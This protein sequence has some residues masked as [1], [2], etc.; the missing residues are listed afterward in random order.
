MAG[1]V[2][3]MSV[4]FCL[5]VC[6][7]HSNTHPNLG[8]P[9]RWLLVPAVCSMYLNKCCHLIFKSTSLRFWKNSLLDFNSYKEI[10]TVFHDFKIFSYVLAIYY[11]ATITKTSA[12]S[13]SYFF[14]KIG[15]VS[16]FD[17]LL[18]LINGHHP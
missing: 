14:L 13:E 1:K 8:P 11:I 15:E 10:N 6:I 16:E 5:F 2:P 17:L 9:G 3:W 18:H 12:I 7:L 4:L